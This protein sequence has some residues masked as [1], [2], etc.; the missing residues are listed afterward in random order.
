MHRLPSALAILLVGITTTVATTPDGLLTPEEIRRLDR[1]NVLW[2]AVDPGRNS[3]ANLRRLRADGFAEEELAWFGPKLVELWDVA[4][5]REFGRLSPDTI[6]IVRQLDRRYITRLRAARLRAE[7]GIG[8]SAAAS[9]KS[10]VAIRTEWLQ[11]LKQ[12]LSPRDYFELSLMNS[13]SAIRVRDRLTGLQVSREERREIY[14][15]VREFEDADRALGESR[16]RHYRALRLDHWAHL[17]ALLGD[18]RFA[19]YARLADPDFAAQQKALAADDTT[20]LDCWWAREE[21]FHRQ[22]SQS[23]DGRTLFDHSARASTAIEA[24]IGTA[25]LERYRATS[26]G[27]WLN[28]FQVRPKK[29][30]R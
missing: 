5:P 8:R 27:Q 20:A 28:S 16:I 18:S 12:A 17:R 29:T 1:E 21:F 2:R 26:A 19:R 23:L 10:P 3:E 25:A 13:A 22:D 9:D 6:E 11:A 4:P 24:H 14:E 15:R 30:S 7:T